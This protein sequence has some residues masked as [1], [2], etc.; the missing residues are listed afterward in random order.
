M[1]SI[2]YHIHRYASEG[3]G[4]V[5]TFLVET[6]SALVVIDGQRQIHHASQCLGAFQ[7]GK[8]LLAFLLT[9]EHPDHVGGLAEFRN[10]GG[11]EMPVYASA[12]TK[13]AVELDGFG[14]YQLSKQY[15]GDDFALP[16]TGDWREV[17]HGDELTF[18]GVTY[19]I[20]ELGPGEAASLTA[21]ELVDSGEM[22][23][24]DLVA[25]RMMPFLM[26]GRSGLWLDQLRTF[27]Q[28]F[29]HISKLY[30]GH[31]DPASCQELVARQI[32]YLQRFRDR[33]QS[34]IRNGELSEEKKQEVCQAMESEYPNELPVA[35][36]PSL[37]ERNAEAVARELMGERR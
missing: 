11:F 25:N 29:T 22:L 23:C 34:A 5:N 3:T 7:S 27:Q 15:M 19:R 31:G 17:K 35:E 32:E 12:S 10:R 9:H 37:M 1:P 4:S 20:H 28:K 6:P 13:K 18:D 21:Y 16:D 30:C 14:F 8:P 24:G 33:V 2:E 26:E 36:I